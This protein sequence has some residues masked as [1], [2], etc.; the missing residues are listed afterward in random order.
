MPDIGIIGAGI[1][2]LAA[3]YRL[4]QQGLSVQ[5]LE[6][7]G[8]TGGVIQSESA[9]GF[10]IEHGPNSI[11]AGDAALETLIDA[12]DLHE[13][14]VWANDVADTRYVVRNDQPTPLP[15]SVGAFLTTDLFSARAKLRLLAEPFIG[16][17]AVE[18]ESVARFT[19]RRLGPE[20]LKYAVAPFVGGVFAGTPDTLSVRH[21]FERLAA[22]EDEY[23]SLLLGAIRR[24][25]TSN[26][27][28]TPDTPSGLFS[29]RGGL[30][31]FPS[32]LADALGDC[33]ALNAPVHALAHDGTAWRV[34]V[35]PTDAATHTRSFDALVCTVPLHRL[36][37][38]RLE[39]SVDLSPLGD[40]TYP[41][42]SVLALGYER[43]AID[44]PLDGFGMLVPPVEDSFD[45]LGSI[46]SSTLFP[47]RAPEGHVLLTTFVGGA[48]APQHATSDAASL[49]GLVA[50][51]LDSLLGVDASPVFRRLVHWP[52]AIPQ[53]EIGYGAVKNTLNALEE[54][55][56]RLAFAGN[57]RA[58]VS[59]GDALASGLQAADRLLGANEQAGQPH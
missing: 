49:Q 13:D 29:F 46:F 14:R 35:A 17:A 58:G 16:R 57:Y 53:Y 15:R 31:T 22:L 3:A 19:E 24:A 23:G 37:D 54:T 52:H 40:V 8:Q 34:T 55:H 44:H 47:G 27:E 56:P 39:T 41:P 43:D 12:L 25:L 18:E 20:V 51:D 36:S 9:E 45:V 11:R 33:I 4:Q 32:A 5:V 1:S 42:L 50:R 21:A 26:D 7:S 10:L 6:A 28:E 38:M 2:G 30:Q 48:R 59:V